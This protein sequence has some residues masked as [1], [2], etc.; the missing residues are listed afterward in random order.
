MQVHQ[1]LVKAIP[2][3]W[4][5]EVIPLWDEGPFVHQVQLENGRCRSPL[6]PGASTAIR[7]AAMQQFRT[8]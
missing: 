4:Y 8:S 3:S 1:H 2:N 6:E 5:L 7:P